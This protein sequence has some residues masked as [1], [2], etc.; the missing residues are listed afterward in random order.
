MHFQRSC[1]HKSDAIIRQALVLKE[2]RDDLRSQITLQVRQSWLEIQETRKRIE[3]TQGAIAQAEEN[4]KVTSDRYQQ[5]LST[6]TDVL[7]AEDLRTITHDNFN[8]AR[9][10]HDLSILRLRWG[11]GVL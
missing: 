9:Y 1:R 8:N 11:I 10:D 4:M 3:V 5:G 7:K 2:Q 6:Q